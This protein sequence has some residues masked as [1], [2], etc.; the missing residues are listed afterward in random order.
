MKIFFKKH[1]QMFAFMGEIW[2]TVNVKRKSVRFLRWIG[3][4]QYE[5]GDC[6]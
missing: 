1:K 2:Y 6:S 4:S 3:G 5:G